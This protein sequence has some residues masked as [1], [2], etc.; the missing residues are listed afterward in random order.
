MNPFNQH[1][2][3]EFRS[4]HGI[5]GGPFE[6]QPLLLL[7]TTGAKTGLLRTTPL[8]YMSDGDHLVVFASNGGSTTPPAWYRNL[9]A[10]PR[11]TVEVAD[12]VCGAEA[13]ELSGQDRE[14]LWNLQVAAQPEFAVFQAR[15]ARRI[16]VIALAPLTA[17]V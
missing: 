9:I 15:A 16:P 10:H 3:E 17:P 6:G 11:V 7:T 2:I 12:R 1:I 5:V 8:I 13:H 4:N 14:R